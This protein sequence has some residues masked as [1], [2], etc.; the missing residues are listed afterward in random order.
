[1]AI[2]DIAP[3]MPAVDRQS[4]LRSLAADENDYTR[5]NTIIAVRRLA[6]DTELPGC[7]WDLENCEMSVNWRGMLGALLWE[8]KLRMNLSAGWVGIWTASRCLHQLCYN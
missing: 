3:R 7:K 1:M 2:F 8:E 5:P 6:N 4:L